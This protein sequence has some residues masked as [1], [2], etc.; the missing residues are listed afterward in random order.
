[1]TLEIL[2]KLDSMLRSYILILASCYVLLPLIR[3]ILSGLITAV[4]MSMHSIFKS[5]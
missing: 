5:K 2:A 1:M 3:G 4:L